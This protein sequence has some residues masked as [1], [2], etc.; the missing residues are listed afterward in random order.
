LHERP[1]FPGLQPSV[2]SVSISGYL[3]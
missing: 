3:R 2:L 1:Y